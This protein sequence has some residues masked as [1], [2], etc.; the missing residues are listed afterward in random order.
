MGEDRKH[1]QSGS[2]STEGE[3]MGIV[4]GAPAAAASSGECSDSHDSA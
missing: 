4:Y 3:A 1:E 2:A